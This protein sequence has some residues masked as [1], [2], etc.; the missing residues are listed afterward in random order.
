[1][2]V[3]LVFVLFF[4]IKS[5]QEMCISSDFLRKKLWGQETGV[6]RTLVSLYDP[7]PS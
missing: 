6:R 7:L 1:M 2:N 3:S 5:L 4:N